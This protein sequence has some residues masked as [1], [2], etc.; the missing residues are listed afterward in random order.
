MTVISTFKEPVFDYAQV[1]NCFNKV[2]RD[3]LYSQNMQK[4]Q[5]MAGMTCGRS[6]VLEMVEQRYELG[7]EH[8]ID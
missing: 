6:D 5:I 4:L 8:L 7:K 1:I 2:L 3:P